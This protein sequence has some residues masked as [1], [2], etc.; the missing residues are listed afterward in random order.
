MTFLFPAWQQML[1]CEHSPV[2]KELGKGTCPAIEVTRRYPLR[3]LAR[4]LAP[5]SVGPFSSGKDS[6]PHLSGTGGFE[7]TGRLGGRRTGS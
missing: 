5:K 3:K 4:F 7:G 6:D 2:G 1:A